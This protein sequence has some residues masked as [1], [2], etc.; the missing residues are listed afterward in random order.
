MNSDQIKG[1]WHEVKG[2]V[3]QKWAKLTDDDV[4]KMSGKFEELAGK[5][6]HH[7]GTSK[8]DTHK[9]IRDFESTL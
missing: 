4:E 1:V 8:E 5:I 3:K 2:K 6:Q 7:Y 9:A